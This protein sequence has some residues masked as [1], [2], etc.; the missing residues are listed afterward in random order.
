MIINRELGEVW[1]SVV[2]YF[3][4]LNLNLGNV[5]LMNE[6]NPAYLHISVTEWKCII[7]YDYYRPF[8]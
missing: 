1:Y 4:G 7:K 6:Y 3:K 5:F 2:A 8:Q